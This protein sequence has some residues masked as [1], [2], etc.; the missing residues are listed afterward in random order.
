MKPQITD[1]C[2]TV[3][4]HSPIICQGHMV[5]VKMARKL[6]VDHPPRD[7]VTSAT[8]SYLLLSQ[9]HGVPLKQDMESTSPKRG[10]SKNIRRSWTYSQF[11]LEKNCANGFQKFI[12]LSH[13]LNPDKYYFTFSQ[14]QFTESRV[15]SSVCKNTEVPSFY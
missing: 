4:Y 15:Q 10:V 14:Y 11:Q 3:T 5:A 9:T 7:G 1:T 8:P 2:A 6:T 13:F 12:V